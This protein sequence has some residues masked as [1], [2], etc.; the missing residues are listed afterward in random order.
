MLYN[1]Y[2]LC[3]TSRSLQGFHDSYNSVLYFEADCEC[4]IEVDSLF[5]S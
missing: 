4:L 3:S 5:L 2:R 1:V